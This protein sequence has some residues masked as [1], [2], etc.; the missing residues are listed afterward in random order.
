MRFKTRSWGFVFYPV[1]QVHNDAVPELADFDHRLYLQC[2]PEQVPPEWEPSVRPLDGLSQLQRT[3]GLIAGGVGGARL[4]L[5]G[6]CP[7]ADVMVP[8]G[9]GLPGA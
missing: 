3:A 8:A 2:L 9:R 6:H 1:V 7:N 4:S 5:R